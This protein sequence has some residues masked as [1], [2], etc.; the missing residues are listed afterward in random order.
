MD[1]GFSK[2]EDPGMKRRRFTREFKQ[3]A[4]RMLM[5]DGLS[6]KDVSE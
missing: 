3:Q 4:A 1:A 6:S 5:I 2:R